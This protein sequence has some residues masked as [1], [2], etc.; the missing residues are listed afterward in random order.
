MPI[1]RRFNYTEEGIRN[2]EEE[3][4]GLPLLVNEQARRRFYDSQLE[5]WRTGRG[6]SPET[7]TVVGLLSA[8]V[9]L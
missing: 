4:L 2:F 7:T 6:D 5:R 1:H 8:V 3:V 9:D